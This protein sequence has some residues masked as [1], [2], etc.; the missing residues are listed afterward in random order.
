M[1]FFGPETYAFS[2]ALSG[3]FLRLT[4]LHARITSDIAMTQ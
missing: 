1:H 3:R 2:S 4:P